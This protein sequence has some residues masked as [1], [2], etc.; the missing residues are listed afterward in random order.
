MAQQPIGSRQGD[1]AMLAANT[2]EQSV[3]LR[4]SWKGSCRAF[5]RVAGAALA[6][7]A[8]LPAAEVGAVELN[9][10]DILVADFNAFG[11][12]GGVIAVDSA[13]G[14]QTTVSSGGSFVNP[15][16]VALEADGDILV[17][18]TI[19]G[20]IRVDPA[21]GT[22]TTVSS[23]GSL[24]IARAV[25]LEADGD[26][27]VAAIGGGVVRVDPAT[28]AQTTVSSGGS[29]VR[30]FGVALEAD[31]RVLVADGDA[32]GGSGGV[33]RVDPATG[34]QTT[35][36]PGGSF[37][38][39]VGI[40]LV[41]DAPPVT[42]D[43]A[44]TTAEDAQLSVDAPGV[45]ANDTD[46]DG[47]P[48]SAAL[49]SGPE[50][51]ALTLNADGSFSYTPDPDFNGSD[52]FTY[53]ASDSTLDSDPVTVTIEV[54]PVDDPPPPAGPASTPPA[55]AAPPPSGP[56]A[57]RER[58]MGQLRLDPRC[59]RRSRSGRVRI[60]MSLRTARPRPLQIRIDR[61]V[62][63]GAMPSCPSP[64]AERRFTGRFHRVATLSQPATGS[65]AAAAMI[66]RRLTLKL[67]LAPGLY[68]ITVR[69]KLDHNRLSR[70]ARRFLRV[71]A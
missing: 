45:L 69:A 32:F 54:R 55:G 42:G 7:L 11:G 27:L 33:I 25:A 8:L 35:L 4:G 29:F 44:Y 56:A 60:R 66:A 26:I 5:W 61:A 65:A 41:P 28:G 16:G 63:T 24:G 46:V 64:N 10:G 48:L 9:S 53:L 17:A 2:Q 13:T 50:H 18:D 38:D 39:P 67:R 30:P 31:G 36:S 57:S 37:V 23:G 62:G 52:S 43:D 12:P 20:V 34:A 1:D 15:S 40:A 22:Q 59:V 19:A 21:T 68:R 14:A 51:G 70:P 3:N 49:D 71:L 6:A 47:Q 58:A